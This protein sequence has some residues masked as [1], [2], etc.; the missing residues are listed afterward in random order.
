MPSQPPLVLRFFPG[1]A[2]LLDRHPLLPQL[3]PFSTALVRTR[4]PQPPTGQ[5][6][7]LWDL[8]LTA[9]RSQLLVLK[10]AQPRRML[11]GEFPR[12]RQRAA[13]QDALPPTRMHDRVPK[14]RPLGEEAAKFA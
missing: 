10:S 3:P 2:L 4:E 13:D 9:S 7:S 14:P 1:L 8:P 5:L 6:Q 12:H 11:L